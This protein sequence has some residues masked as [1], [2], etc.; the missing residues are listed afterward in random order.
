M[1]RTVKILVIMFL[2]LSLITGTNVWAEDR[3]LTIYFCGTNATKEMFNED[4]SFFNRPE[5]IALLYRHDQSQPDDTYPGLTGD[6]THFKRII[7]GVGAGGAFINIAIPDIDFDLPGVDRGW[8]TIKQ[9]A[10]DTLQ[11]VLNY[12]LGDD[13]I[14]NLVGWSRGGIS[15]MMMA[16][17]VADEN[18]TRVKKINILAFDP[19]PG[20]WDPILNGGVNF[21][22]PDTVNQYVGIYAEDERTYMMEPVIPQYDE[23][24]TKV[25][26]RSVPGSHETFVGNAQ[27]DGHSD[28]LGLPSEESLH[29]LFN[30][31]PSWNI[32]VILLSSPEW[33]E[34][35]F[36][37]VSEPS[38]VPV[39]DPAIISNKE[40]FLSSVDW[41]YDYDYSEMHNRNFGLGF[42]TYDI[43]YHVLNRDHELRFWAPWPIAHDR[44][45]F[46]VPYRHAFECI[47]WLPPFLFPNAEQVYYLSD[48]VPS[49]DGEE[50][51]NMLQ[52]FGGYVAED[53]TTPPVPDVADLPTIT[54]ECSAFITHPPTA[55][56]NNDG[57]I[58]GITTD[59]VIYT[60]QGTYTVLWTYVDQAGN[61]ATQTQTVIVEDSMPP[62]PDEDLLPVVQGECSAEITTIPTATDNCAGPITGYT[63]DPLSYSVQGNYEVTWIYEDENGNTATQIQTVVVKDVTPPEIENISASPNVLWPPNHKMPL[64]V[65]DVTVADNCDEAP[66]CLITSVSSNESEN[67]LGDANTTSDWQIVGNRTVKL[68][69]ERTGTGSDRVYTVT[70]ECVDAAGNS[71]IGNV[72]V[73]VPHDQGKQKKSKQ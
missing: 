65:V 55:T 15:C 38:V 21:I 69:A 4:A 20:G 64:V 1:R 71:S 32:A 58:K 31:V 43:V 6:A 22:L 37:T 35:L 27:I 66:T 30:I 45:C 18:L 72:I 7:D 68:R 47:W 11:T 44:L 36:E 34:V 5:L 2:F 63:S 28:L 3:V 26:M 67:S 73:T 60:E 10:I 14:L 25:Y 57:T 19:V 62:S 49:I 42:G 13:V 16:R 8:A 17:W 39:F 51:W 23:Q 61:I 52:S 56:D 33:G 59:P 70:V 29:L 41:I 53:D 50:A 46:V 54:G 12:H 24:Y 48:V 40:G 9:E